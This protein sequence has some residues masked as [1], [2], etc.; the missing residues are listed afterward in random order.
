M[1]AE[2]EHIKVNNRF[3]YYK[4]SASGTGS[5]TFPEDVIEG[6]SSKQKWLPPKYFYDDKGS[7]L[8]EKICSTPEYYVTRTENS[9]LENY[10][11]EI[12]ADC[13]GIDLITELGSGNSLKTR[14]ILKAFQDTNRELTYIPIDVSEVLI[15]SGNSITEKFSDIKVSGVIGEY[16]ESLEF[17]SGKFKKP[18]LILFLGSS[19]GNFD[20]EHA[21]Q[22]LEKIAVNI[23]PDDKLLIG[24]DLVKDEGVLNAAYNDSAGITAE[25]NLNLLRRINRELNADFDLQKF[26]HN[27][28]FN[29]KQSR[30]EMHL[31]SMNEQ[32]VYVNG[33]IFNFAKG[34]TIHTENSYKFTESMIEEICDKSGLKVKNSRFDRN[35]FFGLYLFVKNSIK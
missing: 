31:V 19:I 35:K 18:K 33:K 13:S 6:F 28:F 16:E 29:S 10:S 9:I 17:I 4:S 30:I 7:E 2:F 26:E 14:N 12:A 21:E 8:F 1:A 25:F 11:G 34:E 5:N 22:F 15:S 27:A 23:N 32:T 24:F 3:E 20:P